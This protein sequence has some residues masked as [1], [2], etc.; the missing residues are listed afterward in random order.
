[1]YC[2]FLI[3]SLKNRRD[4]AVGLLTTAPANPAS[5]DACMTVLELYMNRHGKQGGV[6]CGKIKKPV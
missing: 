4:S 1:M 2:H 5:F 3:F 6:S